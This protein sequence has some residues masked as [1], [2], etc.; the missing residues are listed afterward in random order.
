VGAAALASSDEAAL[1]AECRRLAATVESMRMEKVRVDVFLRVAVDA[2]G[3]RQEGAMRDLQ[4]ASARQASLERS[5][6]RTAAELDAA[7]VSL[8]AKTVCSFLVASVR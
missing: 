4:D 7:R 2:D 3:Q 1:R 5:V 6:S 8:A